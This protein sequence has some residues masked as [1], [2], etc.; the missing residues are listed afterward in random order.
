M[1]FFR[2]PHGLRKEAHRQVNMGGF[3]KL[4]Y[5]FGGPHDK[6]YSILG[7]ILGFSYFGKLPHGVRIARL[8]V[9]A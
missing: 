1:Y 2:M 8:I 5:H 3:L 4:G 7:S 6:D 9:V